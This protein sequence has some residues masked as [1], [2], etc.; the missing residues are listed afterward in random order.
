MQYAVLRLASAAGVGALMLMGAD[1]AFS[2]PT[3]Q[4]TDTVDTTS[5]VL[6]NGSFAFNPSNTRSNPSSITSAN[7]ATLKLAT[8]NAAVD[9]LEKRGVPAVTQQAVFFSSGPNVVAMNRITGCQYW[10][11]TIKNKSSYLLGPNKV[12]SSS[13]YYLN[14][15]G[16]NPPLILVG[17]FYANM[18]AIN[19]QTGK[20]LWTKFVG[21]QRDF[22]WITG[23]MQYYKGKML[24]PI[25]TKEVLTSLTEHPDDCC[26][27]HGM[28]QA[29]DPY[30]GNIIWSYAT[31]ADATY[32][33]ATGHW[34]PNGMSIWNSAAI[35]TARNTLYIGLGQNLLPPTTANEDSITALDLDTGT[36]KWVF[37]GTAN[38]AWNSAC[39]SPIPGLAQN[40]LPAPPGGFDFDFGAPPIL[41]HQANGPDVVLAGEKSGVVFSLNPDT[42]AVNWSTRVGAG[43]NLGGIH[44][45]MSTD[46]TKVYVPV[47]D[48]TV[49]KLD[50]LSIANLL[51]INNWVGDSITQ[52]VGAT[53]GL[54]ALDIKTG[55]V[56]WSQ[57]A[58]HQ[59]NDPEK[60][61]VTLDSI[62]SAASSVTNDVVFSGTLDGM[63]YAYRTSDGK[64]LWSF[65]SAITFTDSVGNAG[66]GGTIEQVGALPA[67]TD[68][69]INSGYA[70]F[71]DAN[72]FE[73][74]NGNALFIFRLP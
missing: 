67:G 42:G 40:C 61:M 19:A 38:D 35:D 2:A 64:L 37:Q 52:S 68:L 17:D 47:S 12:R 30:T 41:V 54:Y 34:T 26:Q 24:V 29:V 16:A 33:R 15:G 60:G 18:Y 39:Q 63:M 7:V 5:P 65:N 28:L 56:V 51:N 1:C 23:G 46:S 32:S 10:S 53:P 8:S 11:Y 71:G 55:A 4:C 6:S 57:H 73:G 66:H 59:Y 74:G 58:S 50:A 43:G 25:A 72:Q 31:A 22:H 20:L 69:L 27:S 49:V 44:W 48:V 36:V 9:E 62:F 3:P 45:G 14:E 21:T 70:T 13:I